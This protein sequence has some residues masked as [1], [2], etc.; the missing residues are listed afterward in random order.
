MK[1]DFFRN[2][3]LT[4]PLAMEETPFDEKTLCFKVGGKIFAII[5]IESPDSANLKCDPEKAIELREEYS[6]ILPGFHINK[7]HWNTVLMDGSVPDLLIL[8][9]IDHSYGLVW[10]G[11]PKKIKETLPKP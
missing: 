4:K 7:K 2:Y 10:A 5:D 3:C 6:G 9:L 11:L 1:L 8:E